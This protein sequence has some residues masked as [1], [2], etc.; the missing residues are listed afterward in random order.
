MNDAGFDK[1]RV[2]TDN[3]QY[4]REK[5]YP[6]NIRH[7][8]YSL[9]AGIEFSGEPVVP[10]ILGEDRDELGDFFKVEKLQGMDLAD[11]LHTPTIDLKTKLTVLRHTAQQLEVVD[12]AGF[13]L[14]DRNGGNIRVLDWK[15]RISTR[16]IDVEDM[17]DKASDVV[18]SLEGQK[19]YEEMIEAL[20]AKGVDLWAP[21]VCKLAQ[22]A[23][24]ILD[25]TKTKEILSSYTDMLTMPS[26]REVLVNF[27]SALTQ[28][29]ST[30][31]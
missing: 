27:D 11:F 16:Q 5:S 8:C 14:F 6:K 10:K 3:E 29:I 12:G 24:G 17:Y 28:A 2:T 22:S 15:D 31:D 23:M 30:I 9:L 20:N 7:I 19:G 26:R 18:Y 1:P 13:V 25:G 4:H 21:T